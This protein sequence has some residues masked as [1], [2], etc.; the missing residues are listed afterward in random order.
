MNCAKHGSK[1]CNGY[2]ME[3]VSSRTFYLLILS[4][5]PSILSVY[6]FYLSIHSICSVY[7]SHYQSICSFYLSIHLFY[8]IYLILNLPIYLSIY[9]F[10]YRSTY[11][12]AYLC[13]NL[14]LSFVYNYLSTSSVFTYLIE[15]IFVQSES[16]NICQ[17]ECP[18]ECQNRCQIES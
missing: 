2:C 6:L 14:D 8:S 1:H 13:V 15:L 11:R 5:Y 10:I 17:I 18:T 4:I 7:L 3:F 16:R 9:L 12:S